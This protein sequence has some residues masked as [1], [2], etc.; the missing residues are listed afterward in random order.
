MIKTN[1]DSPNGVHS[2][3][4]LSMPIGSNSSDASSFVPHLLGSAVA[5]LQCFESAYR[6]VDPSLKFHADKWA[7]AL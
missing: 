1:N 4:F 7:Q 3:N 5:A 2:L 6:A